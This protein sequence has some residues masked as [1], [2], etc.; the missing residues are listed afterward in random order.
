MSDL[1][2]NRFGNGNDN[3]V[4]IKPEEVKE[5]MTA[6]SCDET[7]VDTFR[8]SMFDPELEAIM[9]ETEGYELEPEAEAVKTYSA[10]EHRDRGQDRKVSENARRVIEEQA[11]KKREKSKKRWI[12]ICAGVIAALAVIFAAMLLIKNGSQQRDYKEAFE[13]GEAYFNDGDYDKALE[14]LRKAMGIKKTD[15]C[16]LLMSNCYEAKY[17]YVNAIAILESSTTDDPDFKKRIEELEKAKEEYESGKIVVICGEKYDVDTTTLDLSQKGLRSGR[18]DDV[19]KLKNLKTLKLAGNELT[20]IDFLRDLK[21]LESLDLSD[22]EITDI[23]VLAALINLRTA[24]LDNNNIKDFTP[25]Y[26]LK[27]L[28]MLTISGIDIKESQLKELKQALPDC[29]IYSDDAETDIVQ[30]K[31]G[32]KT[33]MSDVKELDLSKCNIS[34][35]SVLSVCTNLT[36]LDLSGNAIKDIGPLV[37]IPNLKSLDLSDNRIADIGPLMSMTGLE[38]LD[39]SNN[40]IVSVSALADLKALTELKLGGN[41]LKSIKALAKLDGL[42][43]LDLRDT[44]LTDNALTYLYNLKNLKKLN[45]ENN[46]ELSESA[47][48]ELQKKLSGC[49]ISHSEF[50]KKGIEL[51]GKS[52]DIDAETVEACGLG[53]SDIS[54]VSGFTAV[55]NLDLSN[56]NISNIEPLSGLTTLESLDLSDN[57]IGDV[58]A[59]YSLKNLK[60]LWLREN[61][62]SADQIDDLKAA[63]PNCYISVE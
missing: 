45:I 51:G 29:I 16:L 6:G 59:L 24:H 14:K 30:L 49:T 21:S 48:A 55:K 23:T 20:T 47:V 54:K 19:A 28:T 7:V 50:T 32:G 40:N 8:S 44:G 13:A 12:L 9:R 61:D 33:F 36:K 26:E 42:K 53:L 37:D 62:L 57:I 34:D 60:Q 43:T 4:V 22:N 58:T 52:F 41:T 5:Q 46:P 35:V 15:E 63:L 2:N 39:L 38:Y 11:E 10:G 25:L 17:D 3:T 56:N 18:L 1:Y 27:K 31:L